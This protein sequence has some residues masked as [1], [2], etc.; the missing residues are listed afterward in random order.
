M[1]TL[2]GILSVIDDDHIKG[3]KYFTLYERTESD[4]K[5][6]QDRI[7]QLAVQLKD[8]EDSRKQLVDHCK[9]R[10]GRL[11]DNLKT[12]SG[13]S[14]VQIGNVKTYDTDSFA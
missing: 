6:Y 4:I 1:G 14:V 10:A 9:Q 7:A 8:V 13:R 12:L 11:Y 2:D 3:D 5:R